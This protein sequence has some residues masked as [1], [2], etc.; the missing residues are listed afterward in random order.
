M[1]GGEGRRVK[2]AE[3]RGQGAVRATRRL[4][5]GGSRRACRLSPVARPSRAERLVHPS[6]LIR[7]PFLALTVCLL[8][9]SVVGHAGAWS[10]QRAGT[11][12][13][14]RAVHFTDE[15]AGWA[16]GGSG[17]LLSTT[18]GGA[19]WQV[20]PRPTQD[21]LR[22]VFFADQLAGWLVCERSVFALASNAEARSYL[23][24]TTDGGESWSRVD[25]TTD[26]PG[27]L[28]ARVAF[29][30]PSRGWVFGEM[31]ALYSTA[32]GGESWSR[33]RTG[34]RNIL[35]GASFV[36]DARAWLVGA[37]GTVLLSED[38]GAE[39][40]AAAL[41]AASERAAAPRLNAVSFA[42]ARS[43][44]AVGRGGVVV[45]TADGGR[46][47]ARQAAGTDAD[48]T[49]V[50]FLDAREGWAVGD[51]GTIIHTA[52]GGRTWRSVP[53]GTRHRL[54][55][56]SF[57]ARGR[58]WAVGFGGTIVAYTHAEQPAPPRLKTSGEQ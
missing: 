54:E 20:R 46:T 26:E 32:D 51:G 14:L 36:G 49:D 53:S 47:W 10:P 18:D 35:L 6:S 57:P 21:T 42:D 27:V 34:T 9:F 31:G 43:G 25:L 28:L 45:A 33:Q 41:G 4:V 8:S 15:R 16:V 38:G 44:W 58:G 39:W 52:D 23:L 24:R 29:A 19:T 3:G 55:R 5:G 48:L 56:L 37:G 30:D 1:R 13:W 12:A 7:H 40:R 11:L 17:A 22:D 2:R 50:K